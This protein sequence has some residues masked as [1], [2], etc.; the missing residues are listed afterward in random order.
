MF[1]LKTD[2]R[3][4]GTDTD[5]PADIAEYKNGLIIIN[6]QDRFYLIWE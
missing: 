4:T 1:I 2:S 5:S 6:K 3:I